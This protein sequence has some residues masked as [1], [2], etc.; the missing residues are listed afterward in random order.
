MNN[1]ETRNIKMMEYAEE[2]GEMGGKRTRRKRMR[3][4]TAEREEMVAIQDNA[5]Q[6]NRK[7]NNE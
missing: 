2:D 5:Y 4:K 7:N 6:E 3:K 1:R